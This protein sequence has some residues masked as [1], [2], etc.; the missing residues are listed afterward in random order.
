M[1]NNFIL[2]SAVMICLVLGAVLML[3]DGGITAVDNIASVDII[4]GIEELIEIPNEVSTAQEFSD[5]FLMKEY[6]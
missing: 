1:R 6:W 2:K 4:S 5:Y 3:R